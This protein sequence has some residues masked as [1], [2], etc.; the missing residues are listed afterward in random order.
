MMTT[1]IAIIDD[2]QLYRE[3]IIQ[4]LKI[5]KNVQVIASGK[6]VNDALTIANIHYPDIF[7]IDIDIPNV[8]GI[9]VTRKLLENY[10]NVKVIIVSIQN[11]ENNVLQ[12]IQLG[13]KGYLLK[14]MKA[15]ELMDAIQI[16]ARGGCYLHPKATRFVV[17]EYNKLF[18][19]LIQFGSNTQ[20]DDTIRPLGLLTR[21]EYEVLQ[22]MAE[23]N[24]NRWIGEALS[25]NECTVKNHVSSILRKMK[26]RDRTEAVVYAI[27][28]GWIS[29]K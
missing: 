5:E 10:P 27:K 22:R 16:V 1:I 18:P 29:V 6:D 9:E 14:E 13:A 21:R 4:I 3:G 8:N 25:I 26:V 17:N 28:K 12:A 20:I 19:N 23:G 7:I 15:N 2:K 24:S 11:V